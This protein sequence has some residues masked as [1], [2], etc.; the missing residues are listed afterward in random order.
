MRIISGNFKGR[1]L[2]EPLD[3]NTRPLKDL[4]KESIFNVI[5]HSRK[6]EFN[7]NNSNVLDIFSG[8]GSFGLECISR[9]CDNVSFVESYPPA[10]KILRQ[11]IK[12]LD[13]L[14]NTR[15]FAE[16]VFN[17]LNRYHNHRKFSLIFLDPPYVFKN[18][19]SILNKIYNKQILKKNGILILH[20]DKNNSY[21]FENDFVEIDVR[22]YGVSK[23]IF[24]KLGK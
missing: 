9:G 18:V 11:N 3:N 4:T 15:V 22:E 24:L 17:F 13:I 2:F 23:I 6:F 10:L 8:I 20:R 5:D 12:K 7:F 1:K 16:D 21:L 19:N 14:K